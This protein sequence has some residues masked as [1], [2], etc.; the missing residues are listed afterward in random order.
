[1]LKQAISCT[2]CERE[3]FAP[4]IIHPPMCEKHHEV[5]LMVSRL[6]RNDRPVT[7]ATVRTLHSHLVRPFIM[8]GELP[9][10]L[11]DIMRGD[12]HEGQRDAAARSA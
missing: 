9:G 6:R 8:D 10:L 11:S 12:G 3:A 7:L 4:E 1:M 5:A 2:F